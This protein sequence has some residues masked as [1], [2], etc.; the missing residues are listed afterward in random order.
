MIWPYI[1]GI[2]GLALL[3]V[4]HEAGHHL[5]ARRFGMR[6]LTFSIGFGPTLFKIEPLDGYFWLTALGR[7]I[8]LRLRPHDPA[9]HG[10]TV[11]QVALVPFLAYVQIAGMNPLEET[12][13]ADRGSYA[14]ASLP[15]RITTIFGGPLANYL[16]ASVL[17]FF[18]FYYGGRIVLPA[19]IPTEVSVITGSPAAQAD[20]RDGDKIVQIEAKPVAEW[21]E[22]A[23]LIS[24]YPG[25][26]IGIT[27]EREGR[28]LTKRVTPANHDGKGRIG[29][30]ARGK[31]VDVGALEAVE[32]AFTRPPAVVRD[33]VQAL[34]AWISGRAD[35]ELGGP[36]MIVKESARAAQRGLT[37]LLY[38]L[39]ALSAYLGAFNLV[40]FPALDGG[41]LMFL[42]YELTTR[43]RPN[44]RVEAHIHI[45]GLVML[46]G[47]MAY[48]TIFN[49]FGLGG[50][51]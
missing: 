34:G 48:V 6:V 2:L 40:P 11:Y 29:V 4:V 39:G 17:F 32:L 16:F 41:R 18:S 49:D 37:E 51:K 31:R 50:T 28:R 7:R 25:Q 10:P 33:L 45:I 47:L 12:E 9:R 27:I 5:A 15:A 13:P 24:R 42:G 43:R 23:K 30:V 22:M 19:V 14:N 26:P 3:M 38:L 36:A 44:A 1:L 20:L 21:N 35:A 46:L 8:R